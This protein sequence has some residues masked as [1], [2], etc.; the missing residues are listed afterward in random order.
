MCKEMLV[1]LVNR[2]VDWKRIIGKRRDAEEE[3]VGSPSPPKKRQNRR[4]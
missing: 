4:N 3:E 2:V 1:I